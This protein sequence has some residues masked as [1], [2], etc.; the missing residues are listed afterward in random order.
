[1]NKYPWPARSPN[2]EVNID[3]LLDIQSWFVKNKMAS[4]G[5]P[6]ERLMDR[7]YIQNAVQKLGPFV[8]ENTDSKHPGCR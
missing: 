6:A 4:A 3:S 1:M 7:S 5:F 8:V 2:G